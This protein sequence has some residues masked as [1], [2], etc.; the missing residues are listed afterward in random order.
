M[1][2]HSPCGRPVSH[3][4]IESNISNQSSYRRLGRSKV[5]SKP[6]SNAPPAAAIRTALTGSAAICFTQE[7]CHSSARSLRLGKVLRLCRQPLGR[8][9]CRC[10][11]RPRQ[12]P[13]RPLQRLER[14]RAPRL[15]SPSRPPHLSATLRSHSQRSSSPRPRGHSPPSMRPARLGEPRR[16]VGKLSCCRLPWLSFKSAK[17]LRKGHLGDVARAIAS[18]GTGFACRRWPR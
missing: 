18:G 12:R 3:L 16:Q 6:A 11:R 17:R 13:L 14:C 2:L 1:I 7:A 15:R 9:P 4:P 10:R 5:R 8:R